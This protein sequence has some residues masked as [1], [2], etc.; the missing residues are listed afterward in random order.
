MST[1][2]SFSPRI[3][4][5]AD[6]IGFSAEAFASERVEA[7]LRPAVDLCLEELFTNLVKYGRSA[8]PVRIEL[9][10]IEGGVEVTMVAEGVDDFDPT[11]APTVDVSM[12]LEHR[13]PGGLGLHLVRQLV[14]SIRYEYQPHERRSRVTF[15]KTLA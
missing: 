1:V 15:R 5:V 11:Q 3:D 10:G 7:G 13:Q 2:K 9:R 8:A 12:P 4:A 6:V 14:D